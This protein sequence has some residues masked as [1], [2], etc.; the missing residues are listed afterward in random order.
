MK[1]WAPWCSSK[2]SS[3]TGIGNLSLI[4]N[5]LR[6]QKSRHMQQV[7]SLFNT[8][9]TDDEYGNSVVTYDH[10]LQQFMNDFF[11]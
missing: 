9:T 8:I 11:N 7:T 6:A 10:F 5:L 3:I 2:R 1:N 4:I